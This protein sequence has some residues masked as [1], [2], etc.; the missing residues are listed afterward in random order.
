MTDTRKQTQGRFAMDIE[1]TDIDA[2]YSAA[3]AYLRERYPD[4]TPNDIR[5]VIG[6]PDDPS[7]AGCLI[8]LLEPD[9]K[10]PGVEVTHSEFEENRT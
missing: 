8:L 7:V 6:S 2:L 1:V 3:V 10:P 9:D 4:Q 5:E